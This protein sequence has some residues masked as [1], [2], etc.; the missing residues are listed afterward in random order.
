MYSPQLGRFLQRDPRIGEFIREATPAPTNSAPAS[1]RSPTERELDRMDLYQ[2]VRSSPLRYADP[3]GA[4]AASTQSSAGDAVVY[5]SWED[6]L[7]WVG[8]PIDTD[9][10]LELIDMV[11]NLGRDEF[12]KRGTDS[13]SRTYREQFARETQA[14]YE[15]YQITYER[16][17]CCNLD[18]CT[19]AAQWMHES[20]WGS[21][22]LAQETYNLGSIKGTGPAG[23]YSIA[24][25]EHIGG[26]DIVVKDAFRDYSNVL[27]FMHDYTNLICTKDRY[28][29]A[30]GKKGREYY[31]ALKKGGYATDP[32]YVDKMMA[33]Y[34]QLGCK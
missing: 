28:K 34:R 16:E 13:Y 5:R 9:L 8:T 17:D 30:R 22:R 19:L 10:G 26:K 4:E 25:G 18:A 2:Y 7:S 1:F 21:S 32:S 27:E 23:S 29:D 14:L 31:A 11:N 20:T 33:F 6:P 15:Q 24:T 3:T 12:P